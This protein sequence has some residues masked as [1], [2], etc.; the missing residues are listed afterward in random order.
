MFC[1]LVS[2]TCPKLNVTEPLLFGDKNSNT[3]YDEDEI[4]SFSCVE[5]LR[6]VGEQYAVCING[7]FYVSQVPDCQGII[8]SWI[9]RWHQQK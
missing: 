2:E 3:S 5:E 4:I 6:L 8:K 7:E 9:N 1:P